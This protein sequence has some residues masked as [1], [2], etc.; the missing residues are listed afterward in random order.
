[1][2]KLTTPILLLLFLCW[3]SFGFSTD[4]KT[5]DSTS[6][7][8]Q[9][10]FKKYKDTDIDSSTFYAYQL[11]NHL[12]KFSN[13]SLLARTHQDLARAFEANKQLDSSF[14]HLN[15][16]LNIAKT[17]NLPYLIVRSQ[18]LIGINYNTKSEHEK[19][20]SY[21]SEALNLSQKYQ[22][23]YYQA[24]T[25]NLLGSIYWEQDNF[26]KALQ[27][28]L[29]ANTI[30]EKNDLKDLKLSTLANIANIYSADEQWE[31][32]LIKLNEVLAL[33]QE[34]NDIYQQAVA[35]NNIGTVYEALNNY[36]K[37]LIHY[38]RSLE[39]RKSGNITAGLASNYHNLGSINYRLGDYEQ[40]IYFLNTSLDIEQGSKSN[41]LYIYNYE[42]LSR[43]YIKIKKFEKAASFLSKAKTLAKELNLI[44]KQLDLAKLQTEYFF[45]TGKLKLAQKTFAEYDSL[46]D[47]FSETEKSEKIIQMQTLYETEKKEKENDLL[48]AQNQISQHNLKEE[49]QRKNQFILGFG[50][51]IVILII[52]IFL[53]RRMSGAHKTIKD[54]NNKLEESNEKLRL[55]NSTKDKFFSIIAHDLRSPLGAILSFSNLIDDECSSSKEIET[56]A[57]YNT[58]LNQSA[59]NLNSLLENL[60]QWSKSQLGNI[61]YKASIFNLSEV[62]EE[63]IEI[64]RLKAKEKS[65]EI[66]SHVDKSIHVNADINMI[67]TVIRNL[68]SNAIKFSF[69]NS[70]IN[71]FTKVDGKVLQ[72]S[73]Q[74]KGIGIS[75]SKQDKL[76]KIDSNMSTLGTNNET[77]TGLGLILCKEFVET[78]GGSIWIESEDSKGA[79]FIFTIPLHNS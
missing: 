64:Q 38:L 47:D 6:K 45:E 30:I 40:A 69:A 9:E 62:I 21:F 18:I 36:N 68:L 50:I 16:A 65:I 15:T 1:M 54:F 44:K 32:A 23:A 34:N 59:R 7:H 51:S 57:E 71:L 20:F 79:N 49:I 42:Y 60:L 67:N 19:A 27:A 39:I 53:L 77:G 35:N 43:V 3:A 13:D 73:V 70:E 63:N 5:K 22:F 17:N 24:I 25:Y 78:N 41:P 26:Q 75:Q 4:D 2:S 61:K 37:A 33:A 12:N 29:S 72:L 74:D 56:V 11:I 66:I 46:R 58:Y 8:L 31:T 48:K 14:Y 28:F 10:Q 76:F 55:I 52:I